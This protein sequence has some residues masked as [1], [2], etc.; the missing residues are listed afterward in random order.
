M[1]DMNFTSKYFYTALAEKKLVGSRC[2]KCGTL[3]MPITSMCKTCKS[4]EMEAVEFS[5]KGKLVAFSIIYIAPT[6][7]IQAGYDRK[8]PYCAGIVQLEEGPSICGQ[9]M[10]VDVLHPETIKIGTQVVSTFIERG[11]NEA[12]KTY[13]GFRAA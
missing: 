1:G 4:I 12:K 7:M 9:L 8:N 11:E 5:G 3:H 2:K 6:A 13:L 10:E